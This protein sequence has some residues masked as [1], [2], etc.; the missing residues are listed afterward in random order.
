[1]QKGRKRSQVRNPDRPNSPL[2]DA[3]IAETLRLNLLIGVLS[4]LHYYS[5]LCLVLPDGDLLSSL[6][7]RE[8]GALMSS[9]LLEMASLLMN[10]S[11]RQKT[12]TFTCE[13]YLKITSSGEM[14]H[15]AD[16]LIQVHENDERDN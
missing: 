12:L 2:S 3:E 10:T 14:E 1:M 9:V 4:N 5:E 13:G 16:V 11:D 6:A 15:S 8:T 7:I